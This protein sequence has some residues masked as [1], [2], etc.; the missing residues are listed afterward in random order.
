MISFGLPLLSVM[1]ASGALATP[2][3]A[4]TL[5]DRVAVVDLP[6]NSADCNLTLNG[7][8]ATGS[9]LPSTPILTNTVLEGE[10]CQVIFPFRHHD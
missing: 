8:P 2:L 10:Y 5:V 1:I 4:K 6:E 3:S 9:T 7:T